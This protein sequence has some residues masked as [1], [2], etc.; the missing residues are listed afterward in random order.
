MRGRLGAVALRS[1]VT[2]V[3]LLPLFAYAILVGRRQQSRIDARA[4]LWDVYPARLS[5]AEF[6]PR[7]PRD[8]TFVRALVITVLWVGWAFVVVWA[9]VT[10]FFVLGWLL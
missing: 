6:T 8:G 2:L 4:A 3:T 10:V 5:P 1:G 7:P 9:G